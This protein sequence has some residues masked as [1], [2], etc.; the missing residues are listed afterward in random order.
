MN[1]RMTELPAEDAP[2]SDWL[3]PVSATMGKRYGEVGRSAIAGRRRVRSSNYSADDL[4][5]MVMAGCSGPEIERR[6]GLPKSS[7]TQHIRRAGLHED[8]RR[9]RDKK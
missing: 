6:L 4:R 1:D 5:D 8:W 3:K 2:L 9:Q 7:A